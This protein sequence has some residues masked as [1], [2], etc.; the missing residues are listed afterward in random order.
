MWSGRN[1]NAY[2]GDT[3]TNRALDWING[4]VGTIMFLNTRSAFLQLVSTANFVNW[5]DNN[6]FKASAA[7]A[8]QPQYWKDFMFLM[9]GEYL[10]GRRGGLKFDIA[11]DE[12]AREA[13]GKNAMTKM[14]K[15]AL[16]KGF[17]LTQFADSFAIASGGATFYRNRLNKYLKEGMNESDAKE[18]A[19]LDFQEISE[20]SQ[21]SSRPDKIS[22]IQAGLLGRLV[23]AFANTPMQYARLMKKAT[24]DLK[25]RRGNDVE[26]IS[27]LAYY[28]F[29]QAI[30]FNALQQ[31][32]DV[33]ELFGDDEMDEKEEQ[34]LTRAVNSALDSWLRGIGLPGAGLST[35]KNMALEVYEMEQKGKY[36]EYKVA[37][38]FLSI[39]PPLSAKFGKLV[40]AGRTF[41]YKQER[42]KVRT[43][44]FSIEN[45]AFMATGRVA[46]ALAN[47]PMDRVVQK[48]EN[49][50]IAMNEET[51]TWDRI[52]LLAGWNKWNL[53]LV[54]KPKKKKTGQRRKSSRTQKR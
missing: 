40:S 42:E 23:F 25:N 10:V 52:G 4:S 7:F 11:A 1:V 44:G 15:T 24:L 12:I 45:P 17:A 37:E 36:D 34:K 31:A 51:E 47:I 13:S 19:L 30:I 2:L 28:G 33:F 22:Q 32:L 41:T 49:I 26:N 39:S 9:N 53:G 43:K 21:Q 46:S 27:K 35:L 5:S 48:A 29:V 50:S 16:R 20:T 38:K 8:N 3:S 14:I 18:Q 6:F 54:E